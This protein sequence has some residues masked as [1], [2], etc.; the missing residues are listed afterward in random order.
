[1]ELQIGAINIV[2]EI[3]SYLEFWVVLRIVFVTHLEREGQLSDQI[4][5]RN[6]VGIQQVQYST[7]Q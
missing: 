3:P 7:A 2:K 6:Y 4:Q 1:M 5:S